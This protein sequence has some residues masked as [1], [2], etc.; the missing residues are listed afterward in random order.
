MKFLVLG[1]PTG[2]GTL[3][4]ATNRIDMCMS[5]GYCGKYCR[6]KCCKGPHGEMKM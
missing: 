3:Y 1:K 2:S 6:T 4:C 5:D